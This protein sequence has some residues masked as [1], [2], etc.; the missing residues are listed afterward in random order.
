MSP[1]HAEPPRTQPTAPPIQSSPSASGL[2]VTIL[3]IFAASLPAHGI[4]L[5]EFAQHGPLVIQTIHPGEK[6]D[7]GKDN[8]VNNLKK[9]AKVLVLS[10][11]YCR[12]WMQ[13]SRRTLRL[14]EQHR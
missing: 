9:G 11:G 14:A 5:A 10:G 8:R 7:L 13:K 6:A 2:L 3:G 12:A 4:T 1:T